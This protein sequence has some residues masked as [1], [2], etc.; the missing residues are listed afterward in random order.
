M[1][2]ITLPLYLL[3]EICLITAGIFF[4][5]G[6]FTASKFKKSQPIEEITQEPLAKI[7]EPDEVISENEQETDT[8]TSLVEV[9]ED[10]FDK[11]NKSDR[12]TYADII[13]DF[14]RITREIQEKAAALRTEKDVES[15]TEEP[16]KSTTESINNTRILSNSEV[17]EIISKR[18]SRRLRGQR[19]EGSVVSPQPNK[20]FNQEN[21]EE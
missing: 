6:W 9:V 10:N 2:N 12:E 15:S 19:R 5:C 7:V 1:N 13:A 17:D 16:I 8:I 14:D 20:F 21:P 4:A 3:A 18:Q 11:S